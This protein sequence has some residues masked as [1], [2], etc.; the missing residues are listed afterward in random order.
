MT[1]TQSVNRDNLAVRPL[2]AA[3]MPAFLH[4]IRA[5]ADYEKLPGPD[6]E[7]R[8]RL[9]RD[10]TSDPPR[11]W[12]LLAERA[13]RAVGYAV[14]FET[15][16]T[17]LAKPSLYLEDIF[18]LEEERRLGVGRA[19]LQEVAREAVRRGCGRMEWQVLTWNTPAMAFY[20]R[21]GAAPLEEWQPYRMTEEQFTRLAEEG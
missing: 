4:L 17:F 6:A 19:L 20:G 5:L 2:A 7:A 13:G 21:L 15:Y 12:V 10:A 1:T 11:F 8:A 14:Y 9:T 18:V 3:D 16:S